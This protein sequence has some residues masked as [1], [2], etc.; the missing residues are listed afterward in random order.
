[1]LFTTE[2]RRHEGATELPRLASCRSLS[3]SPCVRSESCAGFQKAADAGLEDHL[4]FD[5]DELLVE[6]KL[7]RLAQSLRLQLQ[8][9]VLHVVERVGADVDVEDV[10]E[11]DRPFVELLGDD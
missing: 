6:K 9:L 7:H 3:Q 2:A 4:A 8:P 1:M 5:H 10:L 11:D